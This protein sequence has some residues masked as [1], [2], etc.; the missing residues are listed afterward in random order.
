MP[1]GNIMTLKKTYKLAKKSKYF[2]DKTKIYMQIMK[3]R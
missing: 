2:L 3:M 1:N